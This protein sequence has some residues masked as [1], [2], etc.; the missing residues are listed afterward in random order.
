[1]A[2]FQLK[3]SKKKRYI[4]FGDLTSRYFSQLKFKLPN[5]I[6][7]SKTF[8]IL[9]TS[10]EV[11][12]EKIL[13]KKKLYNTIRIIQSFKLILNS[14]LISSLFAMWYHCRTPSRPPPQAC[15]T[16]SDDNLVNKTIRKL[17][18]H[19]FRIKKLKT[20]LFSSLLLKCSILNL[21]KSQKNNHSLVS[22]K[23]IY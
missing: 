22:Q 5:L 2:L 3:N 14:N 12:T 10:A 15:S 18:I 7:V 19:L 1:M 8:S 4:K 11:D 13:H 17:I 9:Q 21:R 16:K 6:K 20:E 23:V